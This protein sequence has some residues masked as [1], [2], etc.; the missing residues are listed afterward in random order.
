MAKGSLSLSANAIVILVLAMTLLGLG[1]AFVNNVFSNIGDTAT[2]VG[3]L[4]RERI[5]DDLRSGNKRLSFP[6]TEIELD[7]SS[8]KLFAIGI[9]N[10]GI[11]RAY[12]RVVIIDDNYQ[13]V[14]PGQDTAFGGFIYTG[15]TCS[16][17][18]GTGE[19]PFMGCAKGVKA[20]DPNVDEVVSIK[21]NPKISGT[22]VYTLKVLKMWEGDLPPG[23][24]DDWTGD[25]SNPEFP[26]Y[27]QK[28]FF[29]TV[30]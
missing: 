25:A 11:Q 18:S 8:N 4:A 10:Q 21:F 30:R 17:E 23:V 15:G 1:I 29:I 12:F 9:K 6:S 3:N 27:A 5:L 2:D 20:L 24:I 13:I 16:L 22:K 14:N 19:A 26:V 7:K 28:D